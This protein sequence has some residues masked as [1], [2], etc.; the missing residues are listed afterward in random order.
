[1]RH[2]HA[3]VMTV[4][5]AA[6][7]ALS[8]CSLNPKEDPTRY[9]VLATIADDPGLYEAAGLSGATLEEAARSSGNPATFSLGVGPVTIP[10]QLKRSRIATRVNENELEYLETERWA[11][12]LEEAVQFALAENIGLMLGTGDVALHPW[13][14]TTGPDYSVAVDVLRFDRNAAGTVFLL[15][16]WEIR[17]RSGEVLRFGVERTSRPPAAGSIAGSVAAQSALLAMLSRE[18]VDALRRVAS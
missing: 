8:A 10:T 17:D 2:G 4:V 18:L 6:A 11:S 12:P 5:L 16:R 9:Y 1:M 13:Y 15:A 7:A 14:A 3:R